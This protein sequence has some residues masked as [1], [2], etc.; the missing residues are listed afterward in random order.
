MSSSVQTDNTP[1]YQVR[2][3]L[4]DDLESARATMLRVLDEDLKTGFVPKWHAD[5][6]RL[7]EVYLES[8]RNALFVAVDDISGQTVGTCAVRPGGPWSPPHPAWLA[9]KYDND[10]TAQIFR[11]YIAR[12]H[13]RRGAARALVNAAARWIATEPGYRVIYLHTNPT[14]PGAEAFW[15]S[16]PTT[17]IYDD[18]GTRSDGGAAVHFELAISSITN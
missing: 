1:G 18:R 10:E 3:A 15:R 11:V 5:L 9:E 14:V 16:M 17:E 4:P 8:P 6:D 7:N 13:R 12:E 2:F